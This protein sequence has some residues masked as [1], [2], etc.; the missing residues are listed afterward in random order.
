AIPK[1]TT[2]YVPIIVAMTIM[3]KNANEYGLEALEVDPPLTYDT[4]DL[5][6][7]THLALIAD[8]ADCSVTEVRELNPS[9]LSSLAPAGFELRVPKDTT[10][11]V[12]AGL[13]QI[14][15]ARRASWRMHRVNPGDTLESIA[16]QYKMPVKTI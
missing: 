14:P 1:E 13:Q 12:M 11:S 3:H 15:A 9:L 2:N 8:L 4:M 7:P 16:R 6:A 5:E 10:A